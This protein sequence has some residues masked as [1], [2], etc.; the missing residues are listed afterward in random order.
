MRNPKN[1]TMNHVSRIKNVHCRRGRKYKNRWNDK[2][3]H[4]WN[5]LIS[6]E[7]YLLW[8]CGSNER[9]GQCDCTGKSNVGR[10]DMCWHC[11]CRFSS[12]VGSNTTGCVDV[13]NDDA[14]GQVTNLSVE[15]VDVVKIVIVVVVSVSILV[16]I[17]ILLVLLKIFDFKFHLAYFVFALLLSVFFPSRLLHQFVFHCSVLFC[18]LPYFSEQFSYSP[19]VFVPPFFE[20]KKHSVNELILSFLNF[21]DFYSF[22]F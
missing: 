21:V 15:I 18:F 10:A 2:L 8:Y 20:V 13:I 14:V 12:A 11:G 3:Q 16:S 19:S 5:M 4:T 17:I 1:G 22:I 7:D 9:C 6:D